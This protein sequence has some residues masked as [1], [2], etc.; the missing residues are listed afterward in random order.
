MIL[1]EVVAFNQRVLADGNGVGRTVVRPR[2]LSY[3]E[4]WIIQRITCSVD[5][6]G[7]AMLSIS[8]YILLNGAQLDYQVYSV[9]QPSR[10]TF[11]YAPN[12]P[13]VYRPGDQLA[14][15][16]DIVQSPGWNVNVNVLWNIAGERTA[17]R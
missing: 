16:S 7:F 17:P 1:S 5:M 8:E 11:I 15:C 2:D 12:G 3:G 14:L 10:A 6:G 4:M 13:L 9:G